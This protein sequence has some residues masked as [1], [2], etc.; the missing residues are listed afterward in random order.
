MIFFLIISPRLL[1]TP[2]G[3]I[4]PITSHLFDLL[5]I[6]LF[7][8]LLPAVC[9]PRA[10][11]LSLMLPVVHVLAGRRTPTLR[12]VERLHR[13][14]RRVLHIAPAAAKLKQRF[15]RHLQLSALVHLLEPLQVVKLGAATTDHRTDNL[16]AVLA[17]LLDGSH[18]FLRH[19][20]CSG[21]VAVD[22]GT[23][24]ERLV[25][26]ARNLGVGHEGSERVLAL[27]LPHQLSGRGH[28]QADLAAGLLRAVL[29]DVVRVLLHVAEI[30]RRLYTCTLNRKLLRRSATTQ[31]NLRE[32]RE[33]RLALERLLVF[34]L[35]DVPLAPQGGVPA[36]GTVLLRW[37]HVHGVVHSPKRTL[38]LGPVGA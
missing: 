4:N 9:L 35:D 32:G 11:H 12:S 25:E 14:R 13:R 18:G 28:G 3:T 36:Q 31:T 33:L 8:G 1:T 27:L 23:G 37:V 38:R 26:L 20:L 6:L 17:V 29:V 19:G 16:G 22:K 34:L 10:V 7:H 30:A 2:S 5:L 24:I 15:L 21:G